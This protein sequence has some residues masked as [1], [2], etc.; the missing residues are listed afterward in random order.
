MLS[1]ILRD[2]QRQ[3]CWKRV[4]EAYRDLVYVATARLSDLSM[5][6][7]GGVRIRRSPE[8]SARQPIAR[9]GKFV[10]ICGEG[11]IV[12]RRRSYAF[13]H[14]GAH[15]CLKGVG[16]DVEGRFDVAA[17]SETPKT[18]CPNHKRQ[19]LRSRSGPSKAAHIRTTGVK[20]QEVLSKYRKMETN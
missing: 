13:S 3:R 8:Q 20:E 18:S 12:K 7:K 16:E 11:W 2:V 4:V 5:S 6:L 17:R 10:L 15:F 19:L 14:R 9:R 1:P